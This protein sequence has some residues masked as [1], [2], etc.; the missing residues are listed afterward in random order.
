M[1]TFK[2]V[3]SGI[4][5]KVD[6]ARLI[7]LKVEADSLARQVDAKRNDN[8]LLDNLQEI[9]RL[10]GKEDLEGLERLCEKLRRKLR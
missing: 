7:A 8:S 5:Q 9:Q 4:R 10:L 1:P 2:E 6:R 3:M